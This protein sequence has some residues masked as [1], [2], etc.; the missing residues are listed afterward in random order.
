M[1]EVVK[2]WREIHLHGYKSIKKRLNLQDAAK[3]VGVPKKS[4]DDYYCQ[5]RLGELYHF[6]FYNRLHEKMGALR[7]YVK[8]YRPTKEQTIR[9][10]NDKHPKNL[11]IIKEYD[12]ATHTLLPS[13]VM[14]DE[15]LGLEPPQAVLR[16]P[17]RGRMQEEEDHVKGFDLG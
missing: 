3:L 16:E 10:Q 9:R 14:S 8:N 4:L 17:S 2:K 7:T 5:L 13:E 11:R 15:D 12:M 6:D 1:I